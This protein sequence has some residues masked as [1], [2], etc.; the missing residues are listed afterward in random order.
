M[1]LEGS[2]GKALNTGLCLGTAKCF[3]HPAHSHFTAACKLGTTVLLSLTRIIGFGEVLKAVQPVSGAAGTE[4]RLRH[5]SPV[6]ISRPLPSLL[7]WRH[8]SRGHRQAGRCCATSIRTHRSFR[9]AHQVPH[10]P[11]GTYLAHAGFSL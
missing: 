8:A 2:E 1:E 11:P 4:A 7:P 3:D 5:Q 10:R 6:A 9:C